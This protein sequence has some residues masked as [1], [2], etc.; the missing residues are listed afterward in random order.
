MN[1]RRREFMLLCAAAAG[2]L[3]VSAGSI[4]AQE[5]R[6]ARN[7]QIGI[8]LYAVRYEFEKDVPGTVKQLAEIGY[9]GVEFYG[10][11]GTETI[12][13]DWT[14][15]R[16]RALLDENNIRCCGIHLGVEALSAANFDRTIKNCEILGNRYLIVSAAGRLMESPESI[17]KF[18]GI[19]NEAS[20]KARE[21]RMRVGYHCHGF[22]FKKFDD[23][24]G[25][26]LLFSQTNADV[27]MQLDTGNCVE[28]GGDPI[29]I[30][31][32]FPERASTFHVK[33][34]EDAP[35]AVDNATWVEIIQLC[36]TLHRTRWY[37]IEQGEAQGKGFDVARESFETLKKML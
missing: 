20:E 11:G 28:G 5:T 27:V 21:N 4:M 37:I 1:L 29:A 36:K 33:E 2:L 34:W 23:A 32:K 22:D 9:Q 14:A 24:T 8:Q 15:E 26:D 12:F 10:Y 18:A 30:L 16:L 19:L 7:P 31:K 35:L 3:P 25:W 13:K 17:K 6:R